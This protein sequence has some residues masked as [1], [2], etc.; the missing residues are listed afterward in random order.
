MSTAK[1]Q[2]ANTQTAASIDLAYPL[3]LASYDV[4][5][6]RLEAVEKRLQE[7][8]AFG[9]TISL[10]TI[11]FFANKNYSFRSYLFMTAM[12]ACLLGLLIGTY[13]RLHGHLVLIKPSVLHDKYLALPEAT[14]KSYFVFFAG[15]HWQANA[16]SI[17][18]KGR[19]TN[20]V[21]VCFVVE[22]ILLI[23]WSLAQGRS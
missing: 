8:L 21:V 5:Q 4:A 7:L 19:L 3:A 6:K 14:F 16:T 18:R 13:T 20:V 9:V 10:G 22:I 12:A 23:L 2:R 11:A 15:K 17:N 1:E